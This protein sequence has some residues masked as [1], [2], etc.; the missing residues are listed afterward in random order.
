METFKNRQKEMRRLERQRDKAAKRRESNARK[1]AGIL[2]G[3]G[4]YLNNRRSCRAVARSVDE[5]LR[6]SSM[7]GKG[8][9]VKIRYLGFDQRENSRMYRFD[10]QTDGRPMKEVSVT[11]DLVVFRDHK[12]GIQEGPLLSGHKLTT[13]LGR[14]WEGEH[15]LTAAD[16]R[17]HADAKVL[18]DAERASARK[19]RGRRPGMPEETEHKSPWRGFGR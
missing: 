16:V 17:A 13:D 15:E 12:I 8:N 3:S 2:S 9:L 19:A 18:A 4:R 1:G 5:G 6:R 7:S 10:V 14:G 11:A